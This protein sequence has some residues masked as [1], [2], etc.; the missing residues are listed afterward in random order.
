[1]HTIFLGSAFNYLD[2][3]CARKFQILFRL[4]V[5]VVTNYLDSH[6][7]NILM[8]NCVERD[9]TL[10]NYSPLRYFSKSS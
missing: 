1:V 8:G 5:T 4:E 3:A 6:S 9:K 7:L 2:H 10:R